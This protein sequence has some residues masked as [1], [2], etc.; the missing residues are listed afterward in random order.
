M[1]VQ[2]KISQQSIHHDAQ[3]RLRLERERHR[4]TDLIAALEAEGLDA[5]SEA[6]SIGEL[7]DVSQHQADMGSETF[8]RERDLTLLDEFHDGLREVD[9][10]QGRLAAGTYGYCRRCAQPIDPNRLEAVPAA[11]FCKECEDRY[12]LTGA[13][14]ERPAD[15][16]LGVAADVLEF[17]AD[18]DEFE[19]VPGAAERFD[20]T[21]VGAYLDVVLS[22]AEFKDG[23]AAAGLREDERV[24]LDESGEEVS[25]NVEE[26]EADLF[27]AI[28][29]QL[30]EEEKPEPESAF[31]P[32]GEAAVRLRQP[33]EFLCTSCFELKLRSQ[34]ADPLHGRCVD[35]VT[36]GAS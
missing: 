24:Q 26:L 23:P 22:A 3:V 1:A 8:E 34:L 27:T 15:P 7:A 17:L 18:D 30:G 10:A 6:A 9:E 12:E 21:E 11:P 14:E 33:N 4:L 28:R 32:S 35:C 36:D 5:E 2:N 19:P 20:E 25:E 16:T 31:E 13:L 29:R